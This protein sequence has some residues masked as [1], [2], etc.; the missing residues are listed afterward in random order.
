MLQGGRH[1][2][3]RVRL[4]WKSKGSFRVVQQRVD[5]L[6][7][8][9]AEVGDRPAARRAGL[10]ALR[11]ALERSVQVAGEG[12][13][14]HREGHRGGERGGGRDAGGQMPLDARERPPE[15][16]A[17]AERQ[18]GKDR[19]EVPVRLRRRE[20]VEHDR[21]QHPDRQQEPARRRPPS[22]PEQPHRAQQSGDDDGLVVL[23][24][25][26]RV[27]QHGRD[28]V[29]LRAR[30]RSD[31]AP[32]VRLERVRPEREPLLE[33]P[34]RA[35]SE[36][37]GGAESEGQNPP[38]PPLRAQAEHR[39]DRGGQQPQQALGQD[40]AGERQR[41]RQ[42]EPRPPHALDEQQHGGR[43]PERQ[44][45]IHHAAARAGHEDRTEEQQR[46]ARQRRLLVEQ[47]APQQEGQQQRGASHEQRR[48]PRGAVA[49][50]EQPERERQQPELQ[51]RVL[52]PGPPGPGHGEAAAGA[53]H[54]HALARVHGVVQRREAQRGHAGREQGRGAQGQDDQRHERTGT[55]GRGRRRARRR[56]GQRRTG[57][58]GVAT[59]G[60]H[61]R[62][63]RH[64]PAGKLVPAEAGA[65]YTR[66]MRAST[67]RAARRRPAPA[68]R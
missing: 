48:Q 44:R 12:R 8:A 59:G 4:R 6:P 19:V 52:E 3:G 49:F 16:V 15:P 54:F 62:A 68:N 34:G 17:R 9:V 30:A 40:P 33:R 13:R 22:I 45:Q 41:D 60:G 10:D 5:H 35:E 20:A 43:D 11:A 7:V 2:V 61:A 23:E 58:G 27:A 53:G 47:T 18:R 25:D 14:R 50:T 51:R 37:E 32:V 24:Q 39:H 56:S 29:E 38:R 28:D 1:R 36:S 31:P 67:T 55:P 42:V 46:H 63:A 26:P 66:T 57:A 21:E 65:V 64:G